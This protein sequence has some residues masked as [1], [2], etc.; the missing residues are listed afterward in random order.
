MKNKK[1]RYNSNIEIGAMIEI[2][3]AA[4]TSDL[5]AQECDFLSIGTNDLVQYT[6]AVDR[7]NSSVEEYYQPTDLAVLR[8]IK[9]TVDNAH[10][11]NIKVALCG[12]MASEKKYIPL[13]LGL[14]IDEFSVSPGR[15]LAVK[16]EI[17]KTDY[18]EAK[19]LHKKIFQGLSEN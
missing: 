8:L 15:L 5:I 16:N 9:M 11:E 13:L 14:G 1:E 18:Q 19:N 17:R 2:P 3:S 10:K 12:E 6:L 7:D 4:V